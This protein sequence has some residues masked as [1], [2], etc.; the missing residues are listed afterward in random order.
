MSAGKL[1]SNLRHRYYPD[2]LIRLKFDEPPTTPP[3]IDYTLPKFHHSRSD[4]RLPKSQS[5]PRGKEL[6]SISE[7]LYRKLN[8]TAD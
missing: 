2:S 7:K 3:R 5:K 1:A 8:W 4:S 6:R